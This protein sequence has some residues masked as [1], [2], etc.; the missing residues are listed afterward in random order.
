MVK[1]GYEV[2]EKGGKNEK[3]P[4]VLDLKKSTRT[5]HMARETERLGPIAGSV[6]LSTGY[7]DSKFR[8]VIENSSKRRRKGE[9]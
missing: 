3:D 6:D 1:K 8:H 9:E 2:E 4:M 7:S 5:V